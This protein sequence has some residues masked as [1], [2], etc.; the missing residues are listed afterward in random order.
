ME[1]LFTLNGLTLE[2]KWNGYYIR[3]MGGEMDYFPCEVKITVEE[4]E[5]IKKNKKSI[6]EVLD[7]YKDGR[8]PWTEEYFINAGIVDYLIFQEFSTKE[9]KDIVNEFNDHPVIK[10]EFYLTIMFE[11]FP[12]NGAIEIAGYTAQQLHDKYHLNILES[13]IGLIYLKNHPE[14]ALKDLESRLF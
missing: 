9:R 4:V 6:R 14:Q 2:K 5:K 10:K 3:F 1:N 8:I 12:E 7:G 13:Y 11:K